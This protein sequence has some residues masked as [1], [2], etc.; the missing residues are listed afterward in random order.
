MITSRKER[1]TPKK[2]DMEILTK[3]HGCFL[4]VMIGDALGAPVEMMKPEDILA[5]NDGKP[6]E[7]FDHKV[8]RKQFRSET[9]KLVTP[10]DLGAVLKGEDPAASLPPV[11]KLKR[12]FRDTLVKFG[13]AKKPEPNLTVSREVLV[14]EVSHGAT[15]DDWQLTDAVR[16]SLIRR[17]RFDLTDVALAHV[18][19]FETSTSGWGGTTRNALEELQAY[20][21]SKGAK[22]RSPWDA[23]KKVPNRGSGNGIAMKITPLVLWHLMWDVVDYEELATHVAEL[24]RMTHSDPRAWAAAYALACTLIESSSIFGKSGPKTPQKIEVLNSVIQHLAPFERKYGSGGLKRF[25][26]YL[27]VLLD[28]SL[29]LGSIEKLRKE[30]GTGC[31]ATESVVFAIA[32]FLRNPYDFKTGILEAVNS[33]GDSDTCASMTGGLIGS[34][35]GPNGIPLEWRKY[36]VEFD[37]AEQAAKELCVAFS[38]ED[39]SI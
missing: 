5:Q 32:L 20:F 33:G 37:K 1:L 16:K 11:Q 38:S 28:E 21:S 8:R 7:G 27:K 12:N 9:L 29:L 39:L 25:S 22:G 18:E 23:P 34:L 15:T 30:V 36:S 3:T 19:S 2:R 17:K 35:V 26:S 24:G 10:V 31:I 14:P 4:G 6:I 13:L